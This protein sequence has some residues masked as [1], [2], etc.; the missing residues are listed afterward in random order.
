[1]N[2]SNLK[3]AL[4]G[5]IKTNYKI[6][7]L[8]TCIIL[9]LFLVFAFGNTSESDAVLKENNSSDVQLFDY[10]ATIEEKLSNT[11]SSINGAGKTKVMITLESSFETVYASNAKLNE[12]TTPSDNLQKTTEKS[13]ALTTSSKLGES[14][15]I[16]KT[17]S[18]KIK[19]VLIVCE[20]GEISSVREKII[21]ASSTL[22]NISSSRIYVTGGAVE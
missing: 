2:N 21:S 9:G 15:V 17:V 6:F 20:G 12:S 4:V 19:G 5:I 3:D 16:I 7:F 11:V 14:P 10:T 1:M 22:L 18:P 8:I 13:L